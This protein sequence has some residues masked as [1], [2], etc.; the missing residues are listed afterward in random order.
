MPTLAA[1][2]GTQ[3][4][5]DAYE[6]PRPRAAVLLLHGWSDHAGRWREVG[7]RLRDGGRAAYLLDQRG[8]GRSGGRQGYLSRF[9]Q[10]RGALQALRR[11]V[12]LRTEGR[13][14]VLGRGF[15]GRVTV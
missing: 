8:H 13:Q 9:S 14:V 15:G 4:V 11:P 1:P 6:P 5:Y 10:L 7:E 12:P 3:L 2:D